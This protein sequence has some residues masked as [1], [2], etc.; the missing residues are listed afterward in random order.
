M[1]NQI[2]V[3]RQII[4]QQIV[5]SL[6]IYRLICHFSWCKILSPK[7]TVYQPHITQISTVKY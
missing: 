2:L 4:I 7:A 5:I 1:G 6:E 3:K